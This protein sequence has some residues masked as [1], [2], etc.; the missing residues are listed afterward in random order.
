MP[1]PK[2]KKKVVVKVKEHDKQKLTKQ[3]TRS[4][5]RPIG[6]GG[7]RTR[8]LRLIRPTL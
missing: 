4:K 3:T 5:G 2:E 8:D 6:P 1:T 7:A